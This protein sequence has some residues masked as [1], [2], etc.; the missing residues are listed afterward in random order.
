MFDLE[1]LGVQSGYWSGYWSHPGRKNAKPLKSILEE[2]LRE[3]NKK[4]S[5]KKPDID[6]EAFLATEARFRRRQE[7]RDAS[8][9]KKK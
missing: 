9:T 6:V 5:D 4:S 3:H 1:T 2:L 7:R 8:W